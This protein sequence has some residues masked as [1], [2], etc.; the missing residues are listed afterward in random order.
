MMQ[1]DIDVCL[2]TAVQPRHEALEASCQYTN[3]LAF[4]NLLEVYMYIQ[5][6]RHRVEHTKDKDSRI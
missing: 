3:A 1:H 6:V 2:L 4:D 5:R